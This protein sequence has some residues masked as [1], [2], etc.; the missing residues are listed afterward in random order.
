MSLR[1]FPNP[2]SSSH[3]TATTSALYTRWILR[4]RAISQRVRVSLS[5]H[6]SV[7]ISCHFE[8]SSIECG[9]CC[10]R[11][12]LGPVVVWFLAEAFHYTLLLLL[13]RDGDEEIGM[14]VERGMKEVGVPGWVATPALEP[15]ITPAAHLPCPATLG[16][17]K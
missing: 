12:R 13:I 10:R 9:W 3:Q 4:I 7:A 5:L 11:C 17:R 14:E 2:F 16:S 6:L 15:R 1:S 8:Y